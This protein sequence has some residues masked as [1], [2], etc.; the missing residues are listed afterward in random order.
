MEIL[1]LK[2]NSAGS[3]DEITT[4]KFNVENIENWIVKI[5]KSVFSSVS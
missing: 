2:K 1:I 4:G 3:N 5:V